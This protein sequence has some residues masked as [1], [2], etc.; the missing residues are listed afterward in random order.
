MSRNIGIVLSLALLAGCSV[1]KDPEGFPLTGAAP[2]INQVNVPDLTND[3]MSAV[4]ARFGPRDGTVTIGGDN[5]IVSDELSRTLK[6]NHY[7]VVDKNGKHTVLY[8][9]AP[10]GPTL[11]VTQR[12]DDQRSAKLYKSG[13]TGELVPATP[14]TITER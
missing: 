7:R 8:A 13:P 12:I 14:T 1:P 4:S 10:L 9:I 3:M 2:E 11:L 5:P 6:A